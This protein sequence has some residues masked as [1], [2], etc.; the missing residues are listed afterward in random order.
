MA[1]KSGVS[2]ATISHFE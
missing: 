2:L 1:E